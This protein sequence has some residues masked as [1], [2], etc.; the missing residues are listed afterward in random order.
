MYKP[1][2]PFEPGDAVVVDSTLESR[3]EDGRHMY[4]PPWRFRHE[5]AA[6]QGRDAHAS[7]LRLPE[8][9]GAS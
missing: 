1:L 7:L 3:D 5:K 8:G 6:G 4:W 2:L 9:F